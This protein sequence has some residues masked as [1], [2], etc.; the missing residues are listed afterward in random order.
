MCR[1]AAADVAAHQPVASAAVCTAPDVDLHFWDAPDDVLAASMD[2]IFERDRVY[3]HKA[4][5]SFGAIPLSVSGGDSTHTA[6]LL[7]ATLKS[8]VAE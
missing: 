4:T 2:L 8:D 5:G 3:L 1:A 7:T 6:R